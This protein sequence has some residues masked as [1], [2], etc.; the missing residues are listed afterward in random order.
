MPDHDHDISDAEKHECFGE[1]PMLYNGPKCED[2]GAHMNEHGK[3]KD[4]QQLALE[5]EADEAW[6]VFIASLN[7][8]AKDALEVREGLAG[9]KY[10]TA[11][12]QHERTSNG[13]AI[14]YANSLEFL[15]PG[16]KAKLT[17][18]NMNGPLLVSLAC[19]YD[20]LITF[21]HG[22]KPATILATLNAV[23]HQ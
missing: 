9:W 20:G 5:L 22:V 16:H 7:Q 8:G 12:V 2:C 19:D 23:I 17:F 6:L 14:A 1:S 4:C 21:T 10:L 3:C 11:V 13:I 15:A 18:A